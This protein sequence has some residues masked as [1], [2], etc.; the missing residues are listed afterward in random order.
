[1]LNISR[2]YL[3]GVV[4]K[5]FGKIFYHTLFIFFRFFT[6]YV[7]NCLYHGFAKDELLVQEVGCSQ[8]LTDFSNT[9]NFSSSTSLPLTNLSFLIPSIGHSF[10]YKFTH[11]VLLWSC[12]IEAS[13]ILSLSSSSGSSITLF[14]LSVG[15]Y[16]SNPLLTASW[17]TTL[18]CQLSLPTGLSKIELSLDQTSGPLTHQDSTL[19]DQSVN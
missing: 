17:V 2:L 4:H 3:I 7:T 16:L 15:L 18:F 11:L 6:K 10:V 14:L 5:V 1:M 13:S 9:I 8:L 19:L 12:E